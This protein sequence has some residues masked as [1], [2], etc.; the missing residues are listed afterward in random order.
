ME[1][2][3]HRIQREKKMKSGGGESLV[4]P[5]IVVVVVVMMEMRRRREDFEDPEGGLG[6]GMEKSNLFRRGTVAPRSSS[7]PQQLI[8]MP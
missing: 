3:Q 8:L 2:M 6:N 7:A 4:M 1:G 5:P